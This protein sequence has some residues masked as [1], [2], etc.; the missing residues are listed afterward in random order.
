MGTVNIGTLEAKSLELAEELSRYNIHV[1]CVHETRWKG[2]YSTRVKGYKLWYVG[3]DD[4]RSGVGI[5]ISEQYLRTSS[6]G[7]EVQ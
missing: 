4:R 2:F 7:E 3:L 5:L 6:R 1:T